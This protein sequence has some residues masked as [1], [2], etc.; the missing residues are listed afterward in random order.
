MSCNKLIHQSDKA[1]RERKLIR[2]VAMV[3]PFKDQGNRVEKRK[4]WKRMKWKR[5]GW[6]RMEW[7]KT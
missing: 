7:M 4:R 1:T 5:M 3:A 2:L 6:K